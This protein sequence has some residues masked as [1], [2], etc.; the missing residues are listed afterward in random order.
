MPPRVSGRL[1]LLAA[2]LGVVTPAQADTV[3]VTGVTA[4]ALAGRPWP[5]AANAQ[6]TDALTFAQVVQQDFQACGQDAQPDP[7]LNVLAG[8]LLRGNRLDRAAF[9]AEGMPVKS[10][11]MIVVPKLTSWERVRDSLANQCGNRVGYPRYGVAVDG[12]RAALVYA[13]P[14]ELDLSA[15]QAWNEAVLR[16]LN[17]A[18]REGQR[19]GDTLYPGTGPLTWDATLTRAATQQVTDLPKVNYRGHIN[20]VTGST[21]PMRARAAG[22]I[23]PEV[24]ETLAY[25]ALTP[26]E[27]VQTLLASPAHCTIIM[28]PRW[29]HVGMDVNNGTGTSIFTTYWAQVYGR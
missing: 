17:E 2:L 25:D 5:P 29:T 8:R 15:R 20:P 28:E 11:G 9:Q 12:T 3:G 16:G 6:V 23:D 7:R 10:A 19:C 27:A 22:W 26:E 14:A 13:R 24:A 18:R 1:A 21:P 4:A